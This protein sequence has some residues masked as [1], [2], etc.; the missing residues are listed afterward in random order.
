MH[1]YHTYE[2]ANENKDDPDFIANFREKEACLERYF[3][4]Q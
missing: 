2:E 4:K 3:R 1:V